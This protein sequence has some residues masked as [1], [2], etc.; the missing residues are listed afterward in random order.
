MKHK[1]KTTSR[2]FGRLSTA[3]TLLLLV[4]SLAT[5]VLLPLLT[6]KVSAAD[7]GTNINLFGKFDYDPQGFGGTMPHQTCTGYFAT[8]TNNAAYQKSEIFLDDESFND[9]TGAADPG[10]LK[11]KYGNFDIPT[12]LGN[13][14]QTDLWKMVHTNINGPVPVIRFKVPDNG[15]A[16]INGSF[17]SGGANMCTLMFMNQVSPNKFVSWV[18]TIAD[19]NGGPPAYYQDTYTFSPSGANVSGTFTWDDPQLC[20]KNTTFDDHICTSNN[21]IV[22]GQ[23]SA[24]GGGGGTNLGTS[25][26]NWNTA[27]QI[28]INDSAHPNETYERQSWSAETVSGEE[29]WSLYFL[30]N[31]QGDRAQLI[32]SAGKPFCA[33]PIANGTAQPTSCSNCIPFIAVHQ[34]I[35]LNHNSGTNGPFN[36]AQFDQRAHALGGAG[37]T[38]YDYNTDCTYKGSGP[39]SLG[40]SNNALIWFYY[41]SAQDKMVTVF[42]T[43]GG[44]EQRF[45]G[46]YT[47]FA[48]DSYQGGL[49]GCSGRAFPTISNT[50]SSS[51]FGTNW[52]FT[53]G[54][55]A[56]GSAPD[57]TAHVLTQ[58]GTA[59]K[60]GFGAVAGVIQPPSNNPPTTADAEHPTCETVGTDPFTWILCPI[61]NGLAAFSDQIIE[62]FLIPW[63]Q[64]SA[65][66][67]NPGDP[68]TGD[69]YT[70][71]SAF[72]V[73]GDIVLVIALIVAVISQAFGGGVIE[74]YAARKILPRVLMGAI[75]VNISIY[76]VA[77]AVDLSRIIG[78]GIKDLITSPLNVTGTFSISMSVGTE[79]VITAVIALIVVAIFK[80]AKTGG[81]GLAASI[82][83]F[84]LIFVALPAFL[85]VLGAFITL[86]LLQGLILALIISS[87]VA[88]ALYTLPNTEKY[89]KTW[90][91]W[92]F[93]ALL[94]FPIFMTIFGLANLMSALITKANSGVS[95]FFAVVIA[96]FLQFL[97]L[98]LVPFSFKLAGGFIGKING[99]LGGYGSKMTEAIKG[100]PNDQRSLR[101]RVR[102]RAGAS[103]R[104]TRADMYASARDASK[105]PNRGRFR[106]GVAGVMARAYNMGD[107]EGRFAEDIAEQE[108]YI[109]G[110]YATGPDASIRAFWAEQDKATGRWY[111][112]YETYNES[113]GVWERKEWAGSD[114]AKARE[115]ARR[116]PAIVQA[117]AKYEFSKAADDGQI[118]AFKESFARRA[119]DMGWSKEQAGMVWTGVVFSH[120][121]TRK[122]QKFTSIS[123]NDQGEFYFDD[124]RASTE[125]P[126]QLLEH[127]D[128]DHT[129]FSLE[130]SD[131]IRKYDY[132]SFR[133]STGR[134]ALEGYQENAA[135]VERLQREVA[136]ETDAGR[137][138]ELQGQLRGAQDV[139]SNYESIAENLRPMFASGGTVPAGFGGEE[140][141]EAA[142]RPGMPSYGLGGSSRAEE[143]WRAFVGAIPARGGTGGT[144]GGGGG[145]GGGPGGPPTPPGPTFPGGTPGGGRTFGPPPGGGTL[146]IPR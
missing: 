47:K 137:R 27:A 115:R 11:G 90:W 125:R 146:V 93:R 36:V 62:S 18:F 98:L 84:L 112:P 56:S 94:V 10:A 118:D 92:F 52:D 6:D 110:Q 135:K 124:K 65:V 97:P 107:L 133:P 49:N 144:G 9:V 129:R 37:A 120:Q 68:V 50:S 145:G 31:A 121:G 96:F 2:I 80:L 78:N 69:I 99:L 136:A 20:Q 46:I 58:G 22:A 142:G 101:N 91:D 17:A 3:G 89:F 33:N 116:D 87:P 134:A 104:Q 57:G 132:A 128:V 138:A 60:D 76:I 32:S 105:A 7:A 39:A 5:S 109:A 54:N 111:S 71:W 19:P 30:K 40:S 34:G 130:M 83:W 123:Q 117:M 74:A 4:T 70:I 127:G 131:A 122:E 67:L 61:S 25:L 38:L 79:A 108:K 35:N 139:V 88:F 64:P 113:K 23:P 103:L 66:G 16:P 59:G 141:A 41:D 86:L 77:F 42:P 12:K 100:N 43:G 26:G 63:M 82:G 114:V 55:C 45:S 29:N 48:T 53:Q 119:T 13:I 95:N 126:G 102:Y 72:R 44:N 73:Y 140:G 75:L 14:S 81:S 85:S 51:V 143:A 8:T 106:R 24:T 1:V 21:F 15:A 28:F